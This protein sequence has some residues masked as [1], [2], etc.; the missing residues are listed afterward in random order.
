M[1]QMLFGPDFDAM[2]R[3]LSDA[4][5]E[6]LIVGAYAFSA[7][8]HAR[9]TKDLD[10]WVRPSPEN[11]AR[12]WQALLRFGAPLEDLSV[13]DLAVPGMI[14]MMGRPPHRIDLLT[15]IAA[16]TFEEAWVNRA[17]ANFGTGKYPVLGRRELITNKTAVG[18]AQDLVDLKLLRKFSKP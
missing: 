3:E 14:Y 18:R 2:L 16:V 17:M 4:G 9:A 15:S 13:E 5:A 7:H 1:T 6:F 11:A 10:I 12:V 8:V